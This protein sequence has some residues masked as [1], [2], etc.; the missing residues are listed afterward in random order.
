MSLPSMNA[1]QS[2]TA[3]TGA[4]AHLY[5]LPRR[6]A[7]MQAK[8]ARSVTQLMRLRTRKEKKDPIPLRSGYAQFPAREVKK[9]S[10]GSESTEVWLAWGGEDFQGRTGQG[11]G[12]AEMDALHQIAIQI[13]SGDLDIDVGD[14]TVQCEA[15]PCCVNCASVLGLLGFVPLDD[16]TTKTRATMGSTQWTVTPAVKA[17]VEEYV[18]GPVA[19]D[20]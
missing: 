19:W 10:D 20:V 12:H 8:D 17:L 16:G 3:P 14:K 6:A 13:K 4:T 7:V 9:T 2:L 5:P 18:E 1:A 11:H 15:K